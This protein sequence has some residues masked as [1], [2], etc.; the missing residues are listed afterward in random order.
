MTNCFWFEN[1]VH[2]DKHKLEKITF[3]ASLCIYLQF[4]KNIHTQLSLTLNKQYLHISVK[5]HPHNKALKRKS[6]TTFHLGHKI[7]SRCH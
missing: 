4:H 5:H 7:R 1:Y 3:V 6:T 2:S